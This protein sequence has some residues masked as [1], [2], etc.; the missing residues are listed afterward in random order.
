MDTHVHIP[1]LWEGDKKWGE[2]GGVLSSLPDTMNSKSS[3]VFPG[4]PKLVPW[5][6]DVFLPPEHV[7][8]ARRGTARMGQGPELS[9]SV[10]HALCYISSESFLELFFGW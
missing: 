2:G 7:T 4:S 5:I 9:H 1:T 3:A 10:I 6:M 8:S